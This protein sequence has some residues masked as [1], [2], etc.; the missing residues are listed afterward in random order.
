MNK[1]KK[2][3]D[4]YGYIFFMKLFLSTLFLIITTPFM[5]FKLLWNCR[6]LLQG[7]I[8]QYHRFSG[9]PAI[10]CFFYWTQ[11]YNLKK[12]KQVGDVLE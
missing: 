12:H 5:I 1:I 9:I 7:K 11:A 8:D 2:I 4:K 6:V 10:N 3:I